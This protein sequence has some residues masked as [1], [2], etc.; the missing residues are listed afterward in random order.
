MKTGCGHVLGD[1]H[2][3]LFST[4]DIGDAL[5]EAAREAVL[6]KTAVNNVIATLYED[7]KEL[8]N[9]DLNGFDVE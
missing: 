7:F 8:Q 5:I 3:G 6:S 2:R 4:R 9:R 1:I